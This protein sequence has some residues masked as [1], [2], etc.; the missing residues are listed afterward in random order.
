M[1]QA[2][3]AWPATA[4]ATIRRVNTAVLV[5]IKAFARAKARLS[6]VLTPH[7]RARLAQWMAAR[8]LAAARHH[9]TFVACDDD[10]VAQWASDHGA[11]VLWQAG[12]GLNGA[13]DASVRALVV[14]GFDHIVISHGDVPLADDFPSIVV[15]DEIVLVPD[16][17]NDG[18]NVIALPS[19]GLIEVSYGAGSFDRH[20][21]LAAATGLAVHE[22]AGTNMSIDVDT[23]EDLAHPLI[24][25]VLPAWLPTNPVNPPS[26]LRR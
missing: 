13:V 21:R 6:D 17:R 12:Q 26:P 2:L 1:E 4:I 7:E 11:G 3:A 5:P 14:D 9:P 15:A 22:L 24:R 8:V 20:R 23:P 25:Q 16:L 10:A 19:S 18:T